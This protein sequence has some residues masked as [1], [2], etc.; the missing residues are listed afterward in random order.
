MVSYS[1]SPPAVALRLHQTKGQSSLFHYAAVKN[2]VLY[3]IFSFNLDAV[4]L[5]R[6]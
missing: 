4:K 1:Q 2:K 6:P 3:L 5:D